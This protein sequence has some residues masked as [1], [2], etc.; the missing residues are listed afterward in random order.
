ME[1]GVPQFGVRKYRK[2]GVEYRNSE[3]GGYRKTE[4]GRTA[5]RGVAVPQSEVWLYRKTGAVFVS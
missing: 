2:S 4:G 3:G 5:N 1:G